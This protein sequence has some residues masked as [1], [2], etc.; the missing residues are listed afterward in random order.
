MTVVFFFSG[1]VV[2]AALAA[3]LLA[4]IA[5]ADHDTE[6]EFFPDQSLANRDAAA[7]AFHAAREG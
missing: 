3:F 2:G 7:A 4:L 5:A 1:M 6:M